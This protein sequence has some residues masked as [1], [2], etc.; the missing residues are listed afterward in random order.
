[1]LIDDAKELLEDLK[2]TPNKFMTMGYMVK[3][4]KQ[5]L[6]KGVINID[7]SCRP[8][9]I[10][11]YNSRYAKL[12]SEYKKLSGI[13]VLLNTSFNLHGEPLVCSPQDALSTFSRTKAKYMVLGNYLLSKKN[14]SR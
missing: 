3:K 6:L 12:L 13:G 14:D 1:M 10:T 2:G 9:I 4:D 7:G 11:D 8:Q 5:K